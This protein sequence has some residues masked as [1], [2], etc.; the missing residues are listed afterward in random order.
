MTERNLP[1]GLAENL[2]HFVSRDLDLEVPVDLHV[3]ASALGV[4]QIR[5]MSMVEDGR[6]IWH[7]A[8]PTIE[9]REDRPLARKRF[10]LA[11]EIAHVLIEAKQTVAHRS[12]GLSHDDTETLCDQV[13][14]ALLMPRSWISQ[15]SRRSSFN[16]SLLRL[17]AH[18]ADVSLAAAAVR[19]AEVSGRTCMLLRLQRAPKRW[20]IVGHAAVPLDIHGQLEVVP[21]TSA[22]FDAL[23]KRRDCWKRIAFETPHGTFQADAQVDRAGDS[24]LAL[25]TSLMPTASN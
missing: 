11:H 13:A 12:L 19:L 9:L 25:I 23:P 21:E 7:G 18:R 14:A 6:T 16:L 5:E 1:R 24:C 4:T 20:V 8:V 3:L 15:Y 22:L 10:T 17:I 2:A